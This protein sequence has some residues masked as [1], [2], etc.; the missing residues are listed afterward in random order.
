MTRQD[1]VQC[2]PLL[3]AFY[4]TL[5]QVLFLGCVWRFV[6]TQKGFDVVQGLFWLPTFFPPFMFLQWCAR[7]LHFFPDH[8]MNVDECIQLVTIFLLG[9][10][11]PF[12]G[13]HGFVANHYPEAWQ[14]YKALARKGEE[15]D[16]AMAVRMRTWSFPRR[17]EKKD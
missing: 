9:Y 1:I 7:E 15:A 11:A 17:K 3:L 10:L 4:I 12:H 5:I 16:R 6:K 8:S 2:A 14:H 13:V